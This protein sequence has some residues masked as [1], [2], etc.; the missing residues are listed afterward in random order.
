MD[1]SA[2]AVWQG[3]IKDGKGALTTETGVLSN[4][5]YSFSARFENGAGTNPEEL[6]A[7]GHA[8][9]FTMDLSGRLERAKMVAENIQTK[10]T[11]TLDKGE[12]GFSVTRIHLEVIAKIP[13]V[14][15]SAFQTAVRQAKENCPISRLLNTEITVSARVE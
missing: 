7:A 9:C 2:T 1:R 15:E 14:D 11:V 12:K 4:T 10:A 6:V 5:P 8:G 3:G 13:N